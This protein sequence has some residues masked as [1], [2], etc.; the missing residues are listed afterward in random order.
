MGKTE[1]VEARVEPWTKEQIEEVAE[2]TDQAKSEVVRNLIVDSIDAYA[3][4][5]RK[6]RMRLR[7]EFEEVEEEFENLERRW[8]KLTGEEWEE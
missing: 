2:E 8:K 5:R 6:R 7:K 4:D 1:R 3:G